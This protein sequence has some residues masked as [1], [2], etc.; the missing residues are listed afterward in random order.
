MT[1]FEIECIFRSSQLLLNKVLTWWMMQQFSNRQAGHNFFGINREISRK[2]LFFILNSSNL[3]NNCQQLRPK[4]RTVLATKQCKWLAKQWDVEI[5]FSFQIFLQIH[6]FKST[7]VFSNIL[8]NDLKLC[9]NIY[10]NFCGVTT[11]EF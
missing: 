3:I 1:I 5:S 9:A 7:Q 6:Q 10:A 8:R 4:T 11:R 2:L